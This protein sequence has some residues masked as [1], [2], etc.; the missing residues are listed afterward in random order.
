MMPWWYR[1]IHR[2]LNV[3]CTTWILFLNLE[4]AHNILLGDLQYKQINAVAKYVAWYHN[5]LFI[6][7]MQFEKKGRDQYFTEYVILL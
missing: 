3:T 7:V 4:I 6:H 5:T 2:N 1:D